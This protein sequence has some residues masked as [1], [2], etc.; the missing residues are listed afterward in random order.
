MA[1][2]PA[3][4]QTSAIAICRPT[5][6]RKIGEV[7]GIWIP[8]IT[9]VF[10]DSPTSVAGQ[11]LDQRA[12]R[13]QSRF[14]FA[15]RIRQHAFHCLQ[16]DDLGADIRNMG[17]GQS[18]RFG[19]GCI[20]LSAGEPHERPDLIQRK[21]ELPRSPDKAQPRNVVGIITAKP[22]ARPVRRRQQADPL[23]IAD[24]LDI[25]LGSPR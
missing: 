22:T 2:A 24:R 15:N 19:A 11:N 13:L 18:P 8:A 7:E 10:R 1:T 5:I 23:L 14:T 21:A 3:T 20:A 9:I 17:S 16:I 4:R 6:V 12:S 25:A